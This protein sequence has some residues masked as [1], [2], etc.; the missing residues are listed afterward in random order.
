M[1]SETGIFVSITGLVGL[2]GCV[3][4]SFQLDHAAHHNTDTSNPIRS[5]FAS[6]EAAYGQPSWFESTVL[7][8]PGSLTFFIC[9]PLALYFQ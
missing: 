5:W 4:Y 6:L 2:I 9:C 3:F 7:P 8:M 1:A